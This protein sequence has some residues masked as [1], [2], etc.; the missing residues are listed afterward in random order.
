HDH[1]INDRPSLEV[2]RVIK[3]KNCIGIYSHYQ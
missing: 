2:G 1:I 3:I